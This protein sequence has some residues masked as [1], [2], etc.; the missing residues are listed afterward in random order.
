MWFWW[1]RTN[2][3]RSSTAYRMNKN[4]I[5]INKTWDM[6]SLSGLSRAA[7]KQEKWTHS[8]S[9]CCKCLWCC[10]PHTLQEYFLTSVWKERIEALSQS[11]NGHG[12]QKNAT[13]MKRKWNNPSYLY[14]KMSTEQT[15]EVH[16]YWKANTWYL[17]GCCNVWA[18]LTMIHRKT[19][20]QSQRRRSKSLSETKARLK[21]RQKPAV[22]LLAVGNNRNVRHVTVIS[23][24][25]LSKEL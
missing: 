9:S 20:W 19:V 12:I 16:V 5:R 17:C 15:P 21:Q 6:W 10:N 8:E 25:A 3:A 24:V 1:K 2:R 13:C 7:T 18:L 11:T 4:E 23:T 14:V 22:W